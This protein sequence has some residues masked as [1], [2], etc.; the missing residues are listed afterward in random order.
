VLQLD[1]VELN[2]D[3]FIRISSDSV[4][5]ATAEGNYRMTVFIGQE[6]FELDNLAVGQLTP[7][8]PVAEHRITFRQSVLL[9]LAIE[10]KSEASA[11]ELQVTLLRKQNELL[12]FGGAANDLHSAPS[13]ASRQR[14]SPC[15]LRPPPA[16]QAGA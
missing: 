16:C 13:T 3:Y 4:T 2:A 15:F 7:S 8:A 11:D 1:N 5:P 14:V 9:Y 6:T 12:Q 10:G